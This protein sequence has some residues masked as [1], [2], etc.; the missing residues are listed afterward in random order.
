[1]SQEVHYLRRIKKD[2][3]L[4]EEAKKFIAIS[5]ND[6]L[7]HSLLTSSIQWYNE[8]SESLHEVEKKLIAKDWSK[9]QSLIQ[10]GQNKKWTSSGTEY[11][12][13]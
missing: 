13:V 6:L 10:N 12:Y 11:C 7:L 9:I 2:N 1:M 8:L 4:P 5:E 3:I